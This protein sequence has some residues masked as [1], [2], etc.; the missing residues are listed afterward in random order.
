MKVVV[1]LLGVMWLPFPSRGEE[2][3]VAAD[4]KPIRQVLEDQVTA[5][6]KGDLD[7]FMKGYWNSEKLTFYSGKDKRQGWKETLERYQKRYQG[8]GKEMGKLKFSGLEITKLGDGCV[9]VKGEW[10]LT[11]TKET[12]NGLFTL[13][14]KETKEGWR[15]IHDHTSG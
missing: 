6:N 3:K 7:G 4:E 2:P 15:I 1:F 12:I 5:W 14:M 9:L 8:D 10:E 13:I 11:T